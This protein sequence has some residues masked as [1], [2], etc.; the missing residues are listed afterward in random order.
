MYH[1]AK[2][3]SVTEG[4]TK[5]QRLRGRPCSVGP[6]LDTVV[7]EGKAFLA[8][9]QDRLDDLYVQDSEKPT[10]RPRVNPAKSD[11]ASSRNCHPVLTLLLFSSF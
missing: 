8:A 5:A 7:P 9:S 4:E 6:A 2:R 11:R 10:E 3:C 1:P